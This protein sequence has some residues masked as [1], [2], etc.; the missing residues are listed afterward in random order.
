MDYIVHPGTG[1]V[2]ASRECVRLSYDALENV[3]ID[4]DMA[5]Q[6]AVDQ[7]GIPVVDFPSY[8]VMVYGHELYGPFWS[9]QEA[10]DWGHRNYPNTS[11]HVVALK[12]EVIDD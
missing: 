10:T 2:M 4:D 5:L 7:H 12:P 8:C 11:W 6:D 9:S 3:D 1:T